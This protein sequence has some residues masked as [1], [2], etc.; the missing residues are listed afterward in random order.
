MLGSSVTSLDDYENLLR[1]HD[2]DFRKKSD[3]SNEDYREERLKQTKI[4]EISLQSKDHEKLFLKYN[5]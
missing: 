2:W 4:V 1:S 3:I 5:K